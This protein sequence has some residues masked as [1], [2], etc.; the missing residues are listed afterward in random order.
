MYIECGGYHNA[1][2]CSDGDLYMW[3]RGDVGQT[4][5]P[6]ETLAVDE[7]GFVVASPK[8]VS[9]FNDKGLTVT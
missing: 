1:A 7:M 3:G 9:F 2:I 4:G 6:K 8:R 5:Q